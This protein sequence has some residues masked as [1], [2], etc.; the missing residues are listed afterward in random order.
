MQWSVRWRAQLPNGNAVGLI[1][2]R[3]KRLLLA[4]WNVRDMQRSAPRSR[5]LDCEVLP[6]MGVASI[7][8][9]VSGVRR[10]VPSGMTGQSSGSRPRLQF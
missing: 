8:S 2:L 6:A 4:S 7:K 1:Q 3:P 10:H 5:F 9:P